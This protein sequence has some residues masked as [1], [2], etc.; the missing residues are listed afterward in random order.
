MVSNKYSG[1]DLGVK[2]LAVLSSNDPSIKPVL[3]TGGAIRYM[4]ECYY[5]ERQRLKRDLPAGQKSS[6]RLRKLAEKHRRKMKDYLHVISRRIVDWHVANGI[7]V[8]V[9][10]KNTNW[11]TGMNMGRENNRTFGSIP[12]STLIQMITYKAQLLGIQVA[13]INESYTSKCSFLDM[14]PITKRSAYIGERDGRDL[15]ISGSG[16]I[17]NADLNGSLNIL[18]KYFG[19]VVFTAPVIDYAVTPVRW[20]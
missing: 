5:E 17:I 8:I 11:K 3:I 19:D 4:N 20:K 16:L 2:N 13:T 12:H 18:R 1:I 6:H 14:E 15:F 7:S 10:G 9:I